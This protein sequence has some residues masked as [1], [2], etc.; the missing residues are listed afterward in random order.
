MLQA[1]ELAREA[2]RAGKQVVK[3]IVVPDIIGK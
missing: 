3:G 1:L 2:E